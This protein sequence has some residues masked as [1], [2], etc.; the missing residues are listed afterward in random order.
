MSTIGIPTR[1]LPVID[2]TAIRFG[3]TL[4]AWGRA[5]AVRRADRSEVE[6]Y[7]A[8]YGERVRTAA[9]S[10]RSGLLP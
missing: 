1:H 2:R 9:A 5:R 7:R 10:Q 8:D 4:V 3:T 6:R